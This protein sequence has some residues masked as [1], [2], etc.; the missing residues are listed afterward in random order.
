LNWF[1]DN[2]L[3]ELFIAV[4]WAEKG[5]LKLLIKKAIEEDIYFKERQIWDYIHQIASALKHMHEKRIMHR[6][7]KPA[8]IFI[9][10]Q[11][12]L[13]VGDLGL[14]RQLSSQTF[15]AFSRVGTPL[16]MSPEVLQGKGYDWKSDVWSLGCIAYEMCMLRSPFR[17]DDKENLSLYD[18][19][20]RITKGQFPP[21]NDRYSQELKAVVIGMLKLDPDQRFDISQVCQLCETF[22]K[23]VGNKPSVDIYL[24]MDDIIEK[25]SLLDYETAFCKGW[26]HKRISRIHF[27]HT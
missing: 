9:D 18:L 26:K 6:D 25:L 21:L 7:L 8:N 11:S 5:D 22:I 27:A 15:E 10:G 20:Q 23:H 17:Q 19:F 14:S 1:I 4:E 16:Y 12:N 13:K 3:N 24:I 2:K